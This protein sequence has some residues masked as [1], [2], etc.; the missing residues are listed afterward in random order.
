MDYKVLNVIQ[1]PETNK[2]ITKRLKKYYNVCK[3]YRKQSR[4]TPSP[5][6]SFRAASV[7]DDKDKY[8]V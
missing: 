7:K 3:E 1:R 6:T 5:S 4:Y 2:P 8:K